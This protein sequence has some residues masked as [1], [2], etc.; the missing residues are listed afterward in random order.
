MTTQGEEYTQELE[1]EDIELAK[2]INDYYGDTRPREKGRP[3]I[4]KI[5]RQYFG[6]ADLVAAG[7]PETSAAAAIRRINKRIKDAGGQPLRGLALKKELEKIFPGINLNES[8]EL[9]NER[10]DRYRQTLEHRREAARKAKE[11]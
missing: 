7:V 1:A 10:L 9:R 5:E 6:I 8:R 3:V 2:Q 11:S 4:T